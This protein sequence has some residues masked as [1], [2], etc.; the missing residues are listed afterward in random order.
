MWD[1]CTAIVCDQKNVL[2]KEFLTQETTQRKVKEKKEN[3][4]K[5]EKTK[6]KNF[7]FGKISTLNL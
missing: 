5:G 1:Y 4:R 7:W 6:P 2:N 3:E